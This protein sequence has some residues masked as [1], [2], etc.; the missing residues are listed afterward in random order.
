M[1]LKYVVDG[2]SE[3][4]GSL[5]LFLVGCLDVGVK[6]NEGAAEQLGDERALV[7]AES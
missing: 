7:G 5:L 1:S 3:R 2:C 4:D 6:L